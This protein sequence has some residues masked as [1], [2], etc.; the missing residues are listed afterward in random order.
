MEI[1]DV[2]VDVNETLISASIQIGNI[3]VDLNDF[4]LKVKDSITKLDIDNTI[5]LT[6]AK[7][8]KIVAEVKKNI[9]KCDELMVA[10]NKLAPK[11]KPG[12][13]IRLTVATLQSDLVSKQLFS[14]EQIKSIEEFL[15]DTETVESVI[16]MIDWVAENSL[17]ALDSND[18]GKV[19]DEELE[20]CFKKCCLGKNS[21]GNDKKGC[22]CYQKGGC[23]ACCTNCVTSFSKI[24][25]SFILC[26]FCSKQ[27]HIEVDS[28]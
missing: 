17:T 25:A 28:I 12:Y 14:E 8:I 2:K 20:E 27:K 3:I 26:C 4:Y 23:C 13:L 5:E 16:D 24:W 6:N 22:E 7:K 1:E 11:D 18:D 21:C 15:A 10:F 19:T 9:N